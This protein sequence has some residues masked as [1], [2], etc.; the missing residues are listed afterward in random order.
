VLHIFRH[1]QFSPAIFC[2]TGV[3]SMRNINRKWWLPVMTV[4]LLMPVAF[5]KPK[6][7]KHQ[8]P[9]GGSALFYVLGAGMTCLGAVAMRARLARPKQS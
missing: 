2:L 8:V 6:P 1:W 9:E 4:L 5:A 3:I 7:K